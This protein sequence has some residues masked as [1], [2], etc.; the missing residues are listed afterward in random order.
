LTAARNITDEDYRAEALS[1]LAPHLP[2]EVLTDALASVAPSSLPEQALESLW[3]FGMES[4]EFAPGRLL[5]R[6]SRR[7]MLRVVVPGVSALHKQGGQT[8]IR[9]VYRAVVDTARWWP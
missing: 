7:E 3:R 9:E 2:A 1:G 8:A 4:G 5:L 6:G